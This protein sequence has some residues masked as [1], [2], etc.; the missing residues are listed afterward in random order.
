MIRSP[1]ILCSSFDAGSPGLGQGCDA[2]G[3]KGL[4]PTTQFK[5]SLKVFY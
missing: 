5:L 2:G 3:E 4:T 1:N